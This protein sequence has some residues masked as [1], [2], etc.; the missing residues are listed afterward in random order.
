MIGHIF[1]T[2]GATLLALAP[3]AERP[4]E[5]ILVAGYETGYAVANILASD[6]GRIN[7]PNS[8]MRASYHDHGTE[9]AKRWSAAVEFTDLTLGIQVTSALSNKVLTER[10]NVL[11]GAIEHAEQVAG[12]RAHLSGS[13]A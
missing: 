7:G 10:L 2:S 11:V 3:S 4:D 12:H 1:P 5:Y 6:L 13:G 9:E 8:W